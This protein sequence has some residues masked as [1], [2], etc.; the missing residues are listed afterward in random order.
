MRGLPGTIGRVS[1]Q[2]LLKTEEKKMITFAIALY[3]STPYAIDGDTID[4]QGERVRLVQI[5]TPEQGT[6]YADKA[7]QYTKEFLKTQ[8][9]IKLIR[10]PNLD[11]K[12]DYGR[13]LR[14]VIKGN[15]NLNL[16]LIR[17]GYAE[18]M[19]FNGMKGKYAKQIERLAS[20]AK[21]KRLGL[22]G[23]K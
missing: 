6:C 15:R 17:K 7:K 14:Y 16:E 19:F 21:A 8:E 5:N 9:K 10:D 13:S 20:K 18:P 4:I 11:N 2:L 12:D 23:C 3:I 1:T 22:W